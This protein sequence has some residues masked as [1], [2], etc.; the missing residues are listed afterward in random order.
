[1]PSYFLSLESKRQRKKTMS[2]I[3]DPSSGTIHHD[4]LESLLYGAG[5][6][7]TCSPRTLATLLCRMNCHPSSNAPFRTRRVVPVKVYSPW[8]NVDWLFVEWRQEKLRDQMAFPWDFT[9]LSGT[10]S[11]TW[12]ELLILLM[13]TVVYPSHNAVDLLFYYL[14]RVTAS[15]PK[16]GA[17]LVC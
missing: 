12:S 6:T 11:G 5:I 3:A 15:K 7:T 1:M 9:P 4:P 8:K 13:S 2:G 16:I 14:R 17:Q 10:L